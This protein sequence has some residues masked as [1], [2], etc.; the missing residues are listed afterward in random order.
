M[1]LSRQRRAEKRCGK[2]VPNG[3]STERG[4]LGGGCVT[5]CAELSF[6]PP[7]FAHQKSPGRRGNVM[8]GICCWT[9]CAPN[10]SAV[11]YGNEGEG[12]TVSV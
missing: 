11:T 8:T 9:V 2:G 6:F 10:H 4:E 7:A 1:C 3:F 12:S 5:V